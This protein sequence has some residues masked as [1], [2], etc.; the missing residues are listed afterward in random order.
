MREAQPWMA[1]G[2]VV[3]DFYL[4]EAAAVAHA[5]AEVAKMVDAADNFIRQE[6]YSSSRSAP[7]KYSR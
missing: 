3:V 2:V 1:Q 7:K 4:L 5:L 6:R